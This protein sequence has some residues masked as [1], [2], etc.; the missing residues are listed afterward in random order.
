MMVALLPQTVPPVA[1]FNASN[2]HSSTVH[3]FHTKFHEGDFVKNFPKGSWDLDDSCIVNGNVS[4]M[5]RYNS[6]LFKLSFSPNN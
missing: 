1:R 6:N 5:T 2:H 3:D 4:M